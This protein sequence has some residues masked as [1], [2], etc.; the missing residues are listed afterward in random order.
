[1][2]A[3]LLFIAAV[4]FFSFFSGT[5]WAIRNPGISSPV[6]SGRVPLSSGRSGLV[7]SPNPINRSGNL[8]IT[9]NVAGG[10]HFRGVVPYRATSSFGA[11]VGS[12]SLDSFLRRSASSGD[13]GT[14]SG[15]YT[16]YYSPSATVTTTR[17]GR[18]GVF[19]PAT[20]R[21]GGR[22][23]DRFAPRGGS[24]IKSGRQQPL[25]GLDTVVSGIKYRPMRFSPQQLE[26]LI[27]DGV[28]TYAQAKRIADEQNLAQMERLRQDLKQLRYRAPQLKQSLIIRDESLRP[29]TK[30]EQSGDVLQPLQLQKPKEQAGEEGFPMQKRAFGILDKQ[31]DVY[32]QMKRHID[33]F[34]KTLESARDRRAVEKAEEAAQRRRTEDRGQTTEDRRQTTE[35]RRRRTEDR[36]QTTEDRRQTTEDRRQTTED[37]RQTTEDRRQ[38]TEDRRWTTDDE[39]RNILGTDVDVSAGAKGILGP[40]ETFAS[41][42]TDKFNQHLR[43][44]ERYLKQGRYYRAADSY[45]LAS[46]YKPDDP[47]PYAGRSHALFAAGEYLSSALFLSRAL[48]IFPE[49]ARFKI[50]LVAMVGDRDKLE[51]RIADVEEWL[52]RSGAP[53]LQ[54]LLGYVYYQMGR[55]QRAKQAIDAAYEKMPD[56]PAVIALKRAIDSA[57]KLDS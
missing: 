2:K 55:L 56:S 17:P 46:I 44:G 18:P 11:G 21:I 32:E 49:Y 45:T 31:L 15:R 38:T 33:N 4:V 10:R 48:E 1:M 22:A 20:T 36:R 19:R 30:L 14:F 34:Q 37:R 8:I 47:L 41:F 39:I 28:A 52:Q 57:V 53:E 54:F 12:S 35:D 40:H 23:A 6:G 16:P 24:A 27:L 13:F 42:S 26:Q 25:S 29:F 50:D 5:G 7:R 3:R 43:A 51:S 9:G